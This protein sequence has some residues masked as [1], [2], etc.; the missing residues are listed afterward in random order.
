MSNEHDFNETVIP[1]QYLNLMFI[2]LLIEAIGCSGG[3]LRGLIFFF[4]LQLNQ[5]Y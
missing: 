3:Y 4:F 2:N 5:S 1:M